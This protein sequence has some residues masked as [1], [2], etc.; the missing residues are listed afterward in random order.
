MF[1]SNIDSDIFFCIWSTRPKFS[2][3]DMKKSLCRVYKKVHSLCTWRKL[4]ERFILCLFSQ[5]AA[6]AAGRHFP[7][8]ERQQGDVRGRVWGRL[9]GAAQALLH[10]RCLYNLICSK[11]LFR[12]S[13]ISFNSL[14]VF[15]MAVR[16]NN[17]GLLFS[18][19]NCIKHTHTPALIR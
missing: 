14:A 9:G 13:N 18:F 3:P 12:T 11:D 5:G 17:N 4:Y 8:A 16:S 6:G 10:L 7:A 15:N 2:R 19:L 1:T